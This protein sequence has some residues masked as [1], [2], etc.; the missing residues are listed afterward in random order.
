MEDR[1]KG[2]PSPG[3]ASHGTAVSRAR[4]RRTWVVDALLIT[5]LG[6]LAAGVTVP[7]VTI[8]RFLMFKDSVSILSALAL[9]FEAGHGLLAVVIGLF[10]IG[11]PA[12]KI[13][14]ALWA[15][16][17][18][19]AGH[20]R[21]ARRLNRLEILGRWSMLDVFVAALVLVSVKASAVAD[22]TVEPGLYLFAASILLSMAATHLIRRGVSRA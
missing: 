17:G 3:T 13:A 7:A 11:L 12:L 10:S 5:A 16:R 15:W 22:A 14:A 19:R 2:P 9:L 18:P 8:T 20:H 21:M 6:L 4:G 1:E